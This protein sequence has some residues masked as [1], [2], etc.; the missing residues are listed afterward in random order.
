MCLDFTKIDCTN[1]NWGTAWLRKLAEKDIRVTVDCKSRQNPAL[2][3]KASRTE[4][5]VNIRPVSIV[6]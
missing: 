5:C 2:F 4:K 3:R 1:T 6:W